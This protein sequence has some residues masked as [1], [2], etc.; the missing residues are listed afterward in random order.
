MESCIDLATATR[1]MKMDHVR[2]DELLDYWKLEIK[3]SMNN[4]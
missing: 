1:E 4:V 3:D 2:W